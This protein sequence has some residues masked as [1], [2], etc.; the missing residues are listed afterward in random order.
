MAAMCTDLPNLDET[1]ANVA[2]SLA[3]SNVKEEQLK[4][5]RSFIQ[6]NDELVPP[7]NAS[8]KWDEA[9]FD[10]ERFLFAFLTSSPQPIK[11]AIACLKVARHLT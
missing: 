11:F 3:Y 2:S 1:I 7:Q 6:K 8:L 5:I 4:V 9:L 10:S